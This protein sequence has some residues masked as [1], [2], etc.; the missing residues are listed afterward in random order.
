MSEPVEPDPK[1]AID[2]SAYIP[3]FLEQARLFLD[4]L[5]RH[6]IQLQTHPDDATS[7]R[8]AYRAAHTLKGMAATMRYDA[9]AAM[10]KAM[11]DRLSPQSPLP[12]EQIRSLLAGCDE[13]WAGLAQ[14]AE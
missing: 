9:L 5:Q 12:L 3:L 14:L 8:E 11:E 7:L 6:L 2:L 4:D 1:P 13:Y 10:A